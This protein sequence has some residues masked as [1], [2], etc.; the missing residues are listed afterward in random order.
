[1][2]DPVISL[3]AIERYQQRV[4]DVPAAE[5]LRR[6]VTPALRAAIEFGAESA[7]LPSRHRLVIV[8]DTVVTIRPDDGPARRNRGRTRRCGCRPRSWSDES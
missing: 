7:R 8:G 1:M 6:L 5:V 3:H 4:E 2:S